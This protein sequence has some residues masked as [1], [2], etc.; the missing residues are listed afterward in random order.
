MKTF[1]LLKIEVASK[2][3]PL[4]DGVIINQENSRRSWLIEV[5]TTP[6]Y[7]AY[8]QQ[9][10]DQLVA[11]RA[12]I[13]FPDNEPAPFEVVVHAIEQIDHEHISVLLLGK[14]TASR[15][16]Y[17]EKLLANLLEQNLNA[18]QLLTQFTEGMKKR[19]KL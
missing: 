1:K 8:F 14:L 3:I 11:A 18:E 7:Q 17:A 16:K 4:I 5:F 15:S 10:N 6:E 12:V 9:L 2:D 19:P 13:S